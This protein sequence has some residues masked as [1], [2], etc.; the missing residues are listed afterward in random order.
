LL[1]VCDPSVLQRRYFSPHWG[2]MS[3]LLSRS[4][5]EMLISA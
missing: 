4:R 3:L 2:P 1:P 5:D